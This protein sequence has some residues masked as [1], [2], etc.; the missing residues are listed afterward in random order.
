[1]PFQHCQFYNVPDVTLLFPA[2]ALRSLLSTYSTKFGKS[3]AP[4]YVTDMKQHPL[5]LSSITFVLSKNII[6]K[7]LV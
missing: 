4:S 6:R 7:P 5:G 2:V 3:L 1:M